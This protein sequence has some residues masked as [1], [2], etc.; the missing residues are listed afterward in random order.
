MFIKSTGYSVRYSC[1]CFLVFLGDIYL[2][3]E[4][5]RER[6]GYDIIKAQWIIDF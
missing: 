3:G 1:L 4:V 6:K 5:F 2:K